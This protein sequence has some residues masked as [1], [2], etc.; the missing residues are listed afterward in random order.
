MANKRFRPGRILA[1][2]AL[3]VVALTVATAPAAAA[4]VSLLGSP[5][6]SLL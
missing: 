5:Q 1:V 3:A 4:W 2:A 6:V